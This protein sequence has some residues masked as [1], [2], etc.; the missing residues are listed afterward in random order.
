MGIRSSRRCEP[1]SV[2]LG[3]LWHRMPDPVELPGYKFLGWG[4]GATSGASG[5]R[6]ASD[7]FGRCGACGALLRIWNDKS[8]QCTCGRLYKDVEAGRFGSSDGD[9]SIAVYRRLS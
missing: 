4:P 2:G 3:A 1:S 8:E 5:W 6:L 7:Y 9:G